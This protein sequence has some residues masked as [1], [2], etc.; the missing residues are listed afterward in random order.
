M[1]SWEHGERKC[2]R[3][4]LSSCRPGKLGSNTLLKSPRGKPP[5]AVTPGLR[6]PREL[7][8]STACA[9]TGLRL[10][11]VTH[12]TPHH[13]TACQSE[14]R[15]ANITKGG[16]QRNRHQRPGIS[17]PCCFPNKEL[18]PLPPWSNLTR[19]AFCVPNQALRFTSRC[20]RDL[21]QS[22][23]ECLIRWLAC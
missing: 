13:A 9:Q 7:A 2:L 1:D 22:F 20:H 3:G 12:L 11:G 10:T 14:A 17:C 19:E 23:S 21:S 16:E 6:W 18:L 5:S 8:C 4:P 15:N